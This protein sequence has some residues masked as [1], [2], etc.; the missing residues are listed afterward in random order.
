ML[1]E[2]SN[3]VGGVRNLEQYGTSDSHLS[4]TRFDILEHDRHRGV[5]IELPTLSDQD[6]VTIIK[7]RIT[8]PLTPIETDSW[9]LQR[10]NDLTRPGEGKQERRPLFAAMLGN[11]LNMQ[12]SKA[13]EAYLDGVKRIDKRKEL[14]ELLINRDR[15]N[16]WFKNEHSPA[17]NAH[18]KYENLLALCTFTRGLSLEVLDELSQQGVKLLPTFQEFDANIY[19]LMASNNKDRFNLGFL[20]PDFIGEYFVL[21]HLRSQSRGAREELI[22]LA[23][24]YGKKEAAQFVRLCHQ[25][26]PD[27]VFQQQYLLPAPGQHL[28]Y[29][30]SLL[31]D[32]LHDWR[33]SLEIVKQKDLDFDLGAIR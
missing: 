28:E 9:L 4:R 14:I 18:S 13:N 24:Q 3:T 30:A 20:Q 16:Y 1:L 5:G 2:R 27:L 19:R 26:H 29:V 17:P 23:W 33:G 21:D 10:L 12:E 22:E 7:N 11:A 32:I 31:R 15:H 6:V 25:N 8:R